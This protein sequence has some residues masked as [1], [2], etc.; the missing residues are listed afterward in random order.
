METSTASPLAS[1][2][3]SEKT[4]ERVR[5]TLSLVSHTNVGKTTLARTLLRRDV[6]EVLDQA[7][8][9]ME[10]AGYPLLET[11][12]AELMLWDTPGFGDSAR[13]LGRLRRHEQ[14]LKWFFS[15]LWD[16]LTDKPLWSSQQ[17]A[18]NIRD[19]A[20]VVLYLVNAAEEP[21]DA[22]YVVPEL[23]LLE[24]IGRPVVLLL[25]QTGDL[26]PGGALLAERVE[27]W[28]RHFERFQVVRGV[29]TLD[30]FSRC[31]VQE[32]ELFERL[33]PWLEEA[34]RPA[35]AALR[36]A[37]DAQSLAI[38]RRAVR[39][40][41]TYL[42][43]TAADRETLPTR[44]PSKEEKEGAFQTLAERLEERTH[45]LT[46]ALL[47]AHGL[48]GR[49]AEAIE[50]RLDAFQVEGEDRIDTE[51]G[52]LLGG[53]VSG[54]VGGLAADLLAGG[55][56]F[57][58]G[59]LAGAILGALGGAGL[60]RGYQLL[61]AGKKA[62]VGWTPPFLERLTGRTVLRYLAVAHFGRGRGELLDW[63]EE[64]RRW[65]DAVG[66]AL[67]RGGEG[68][69]E[70]WKRMAGAEDADAEAVGLWLERAVRDTLTGL[71]PRA[72][73]LFEHGPPP[74]LADGDSMLRGVNERASGG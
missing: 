32:G 69:A 66:A 1:P 68:R 14:P 30:A 29:F 10:S 62:A 50:R 57:G 7:H 25:N 35:M 37:W 13:L 33:E 56:T 27:A 16:R 55:L 43:R 53:M 31:W 36:R 52:A 67:E 41:G 72:S 6:G 12:D 70:L 74:E 17:A 40:M 73:R 65:R 21:E 42:A 71:Y 8:V 11:R 58:G 19:E 23:E 15:Q 47:L 26:D 46:S 18:L 2:S 45:E 61:A 49:A 44:R 64:P 9:T 20:D 60:A 24:W 28:R 5:V 38:F 39:A 4:G 54:A 3:P 34:K 51:K 48:E 63:A 59:M 22:G